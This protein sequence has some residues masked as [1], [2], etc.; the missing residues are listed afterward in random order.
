V[1]HHNQGTTNPDAHCQR[2]SPSQI[3]GLATPV[4]LLLI[5]IEYAQADTHSA[6][7]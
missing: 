6:Q 1:A 2:M 5:A 4:F 7:H 3:I